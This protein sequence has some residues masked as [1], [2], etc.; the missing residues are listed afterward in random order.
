[1]LATLEICE[2]IINLE[3]NMLTHFE[4]LNK[5]LL[6]I[7]DVKIKALQ[8]ENQRLCNKINKKKVFF[9]KKTETCYNNALHGII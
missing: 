7:K 9:L 6:N 1:M 8:I 4:G 5:E 2:L 3:K